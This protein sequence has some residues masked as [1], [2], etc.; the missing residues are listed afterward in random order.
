MPIVIMLFAE[1]AQ[2][3]GEALLL[4]RL[5]AILHALRVGAFA[6]RVERF[7][8][9]EGVFE[10]FYKS[11]TYFAG[12][13][14]SGGFVVK[15]ADGGLVPEALVQDLKIAAERSNGFRGLY[16]GNSHGPVQ[17]GVRGQVNFK[18]SW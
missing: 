17:I 7:I 5:S 4:A 2:G 16:V 1:L 18:A 14:R 6:F 8:D 12:I 13:E 11:K 3:A 15:A 9:H 10:L